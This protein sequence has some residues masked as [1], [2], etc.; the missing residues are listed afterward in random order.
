[1]GDLLFMSLYF[2]TFTEVYLILSVIK[3]TWYLSIELLVV[4]PK[5]RQ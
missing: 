5:E 3:G 1:M 4:L 2:I